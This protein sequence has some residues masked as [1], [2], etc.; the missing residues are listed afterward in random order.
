[1]PFFGGGGGDYHI[2]A[3][4]IKGGTAAAPAVT[5]SN[6][7]ALGNGALT[8]LDVG[9]NNISV[10]NLAGASITNGGNNL[11]IGYRA[12]TDVIS[13]SS[14]LIVIGNGAL[15]STDNTSSSSVVIGEG[16]A[17]SCGSVGGSVVVGYGAQYNQN[18]LANSVVIG[19]NAHV[20]NINPLVSV[21]SS[22]SI[23]NNA[24]SQSYGVAIGSQAV[25]AQKSIAIG[26]FVTAPA[27]G[28]VIGDAS[29]TSIFIGGKDFSAG[30]GGISSSTYAALPA[31]GASSGVMYFVSDIGPSGSLFRS[32]G[33]EWVPVNGECVLLRG[34]YPVAMANNGSVAAN[35]AL[36]LS[37]TGL[38]AVYSGG[39][40]LY[41]PAGAAYAGSVAGF[42]WTVMT[43]AT[44]GTIYNSIGDATTTFLNGTK[45]ALTPIVA[46]GPG[47][48]L[49]VGSNT[50][51]GHYDLPVG[52]LGESG[53]LEGIYS[54]TFSSSASSKGAQIYFDFQQIN[55]MVATTANSFNGY[56]NTRNRGVANQINNFNGLI[57]TSNTG[58]ITF[59]TINTALSKPIDMLISNTGSNN[60]TMVMESFELRLKKS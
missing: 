20:T 45:G 18:K 34:N 35:G 44:V 46:A 14:S 53:S 29:Y 49:G 22:V 59:T 4:N 8:L 28:V 58:G 41:L 27:D 3:T 26:Y 50:Q 6:N 11:F 30:P 12:G 21:T 16:A 37:S 25:S 17:F 57:Q 15:T 40:W 24:E 47:A 1:M 38:N 31:A 55:A 56:M 60:D 33:T 9:S 36:T 43:T 5:G 2:V 52:L 13:N 42:Y 51:C 48:F 23:G 7:M 10:G 19:N 54:C 32:N 39:L